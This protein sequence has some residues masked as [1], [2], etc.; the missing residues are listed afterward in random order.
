MRIEINLAPLKDVFV[1]DLVDVKPGIGGGNQTT[2]EGKLKSEAT[3]L[4]LRIVKNP[5]KV[6]NL[7]FQQQQK[8][9][10]N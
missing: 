9:R 4:E 8:I 10:S 5:P 3:H 2:G 6:E 7:L 1:D